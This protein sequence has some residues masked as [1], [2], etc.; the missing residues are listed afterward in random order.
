MNIFIPE[1]MACR[2]FPPW[3]VESVQRG[4]IPPSAGPPLQCIEILPPLGSGDFQKEDDTIEVLSSNM[5]MYR[6]SIETGCVDP[7]RPGTPAAQG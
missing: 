6:R 2:I 3:S 4:S 1:H 5:R 7:T